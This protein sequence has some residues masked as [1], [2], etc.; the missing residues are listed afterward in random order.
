MDD[1][2]KQAKR[3]A[4]MV[5]YNQLPHRKEYRRQASKNKSANHKL[6]TT[7]KRLTEHSIDEL[8]MIACQKYAE[9]GL[10][11]DSHIDAVRDVLEVLHGSRRVLS[12]AHVDTI[13]A[14]QPPTVNHSDQENDN[15]DNPSQ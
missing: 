2:E 12:G 15:A 14:D 6:E 11:F 7:A 4:R 5:E 9:A 13:C 1:V 10:D 3:N 8:L